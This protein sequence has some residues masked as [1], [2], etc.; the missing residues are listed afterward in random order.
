MPRQIITLGGGGF[1]TKSEPGL[2]EYLLAQSGEARPKIG[3]VGTASGDSETYLLKFY[4]RF[5]KLNCEPSH[6]AF[7]RSTPKI[8]D[9]VM[10]QDIIFVGGGNT[11]SMLAIWSD[12]GVPTHLKAALDEG[13]IL[14]GISAG[15]IC[16]FEAGVTDSFAGELRA[17]PCLGFLEGSC[18]PHYSGEVERRPAYRKL[19]E[20]G[21]IPPGIAIDDGVAVHF[22]DGNPSRIVSGVGEASAYAVSMQDGVLSEEVL[23]DVEQLSVAT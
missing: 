23:S 18:C 15:A 8:S 21:E 2:D 3:F 10:Q 14:S 11:K 16:W 9:W 20:N 17:L 7:F 12:W 6:L 1:S 5:S 13:V 22:I 4:T 19:V